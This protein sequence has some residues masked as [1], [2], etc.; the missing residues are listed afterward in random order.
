MCTGMSC[1][2]KDLFIICTCTEHLGKV[3]LNTLAVITIRG[4]TGLHA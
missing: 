2:I 4:H 3:H 1:I